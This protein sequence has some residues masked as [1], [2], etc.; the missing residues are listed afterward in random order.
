VPIHRFLVAPVRGAKH[1]PPLSSLKTQNPPKDRG[2]GRRARHGFDGSAS[3]PRPTRSGTPRD[4]DRMMAHLFR[5][6]GA[7][8][9]CLGGQANR[10]RRELASSICDSEFRKEKL[11][12][13]GVWDKRGRPTMARWIEITLVLLCLGA[14]AP[15]AF[16]HKEATHEPLEK[17]ELAC[18]SKSRQC[19]G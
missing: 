8:A 12:E 15:I 6:S 18:I 3:R 2:C 14:A 5:A 17:P 16:R 11:N 13:K 7:I 9:F 4:T 10:S 19:F 1:R